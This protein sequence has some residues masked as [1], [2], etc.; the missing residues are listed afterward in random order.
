M[1]D[2]PLRSCKTHEIPPT[3]FK[4]IQPVDMKL[5][6]C[7]KWPVYFQLSIVT[8]HLIGLH[9]NHSNN[10]VTSGRHVGFSNFQIFFIFEFSEKTTF[11]DWNYK[12]VRSIVKS[13]VFRRK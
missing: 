1:T 5:G 6:M 11:S 9:G 7:N 10:D 8:W 3:I 2:L 12:I 13:S 4:S